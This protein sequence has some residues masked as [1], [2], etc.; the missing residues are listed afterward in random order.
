MAADIS[1]FCSALA[2]AST[3]IGEF[4]VSACRIDVEQ[5]GDVANVLA[6]RRREG[7]GHLLTKGSHFS[8]HF[9]SKGLH[10]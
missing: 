2:L 9:L 4:D 5:V 3:G 7:G 8:T 10:F 6:H 1:D